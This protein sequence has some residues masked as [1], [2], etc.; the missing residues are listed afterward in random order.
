M[1]LMLSFER[2]DVPKDAGVIL[3]CSKFLIQ[4]VEPFAD[5]ATFRGAESNSKAR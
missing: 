4:L 1:K 5:K 3:P 2:S